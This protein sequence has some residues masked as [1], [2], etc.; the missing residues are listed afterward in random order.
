AKF[1]QKNSNRFLKSIISYSPSTH[2]WSTCQIRNNWVE[3]RVVRFVTSQL[4]TN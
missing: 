2:A 1:D 3:F 4:K